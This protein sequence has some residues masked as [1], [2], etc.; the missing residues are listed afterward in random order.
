LTLATKVR[1]GKVGLTVDANLDVR[2]CCKHAVPA[3]FELAVLL[4][5]LGFSR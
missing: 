4:K 3:N 5:V 2:R 1:F